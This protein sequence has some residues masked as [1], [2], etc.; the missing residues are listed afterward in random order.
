[1]SFVFCKITSESK[2]FKMINTNTILILLLILLSSCNKSQSENQ[3]YNSK[4]YSTKTFQSD[5]LNY[6]FKVPQARKLYEEGRKYYE[7]KEFNKAIESY[8]NSLKF[9][10]LSGTYNELGIA[11]RTIN[12]YTNSVNTYLEGINNFKDS[13]S[14]YFNLANVY[15]KMGDYEN[16]K[17][18]LEIILNK[19]DS[20]FW[21][22]YTNLHLAT[23]YYNDHKIEKAR[24]YMSKIKKLQNNPTF[25]DLHNSIKQRIDSY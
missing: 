20:Q 13:W 12:D 10:K 16:S 22:D 5:D 4:Y 2:I 1:M 25:T 14:I 7:D 6:D 15:A 21:K 19:T 3:N 8:K 18:Y 11:Y 9:E 23:I 17:K 24:E